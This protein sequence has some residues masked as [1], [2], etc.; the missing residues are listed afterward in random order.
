M[1]EG[2]PMMA[3]YAHSLFREAYR[4]EGEI[5]EAVQHGL[6]ALKLGMSTGRLPLAKTEAALLVGC[7]LNFGVH[8]DRG[9]IERAGLSIGS[10]LERAQERLTWMKAMSRV[11]DIEYERDMKKLEGVMS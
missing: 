8:L 9:A 10:A 11:T 5:P 7:S 6:A 2:D 4:C 3:A 1:D